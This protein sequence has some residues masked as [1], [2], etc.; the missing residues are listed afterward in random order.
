MQKFLIANQRR[1]RRAKDEEAKNDKTTIQH[2]SSFCSFWLAKP[3]KDKE[4][5][6]FT[7][8]P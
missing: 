3:L 4:H 8:Y 7:Y 6:L 5:G 1:E 2:L